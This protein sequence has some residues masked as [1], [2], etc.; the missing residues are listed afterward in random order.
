MNNLDKSW[1]RFY[2]SNNNMEKGKK[3][4][5]K[6]QI[7]NDIYLR[8]CVRI[9]TTLLDIDICHLISGFI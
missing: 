2:I 8:I 4:W 7:K 9:L 1:D 3:K 5:I 6:T